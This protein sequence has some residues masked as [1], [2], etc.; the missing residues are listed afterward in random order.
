MRLRDQ[1]LAVSDAFAKAVRRSEAR[2]STIV[3][4]SGNAISRLR[5]GADM[6]SERVHNGLQWFSDNWPLLADA[7][8][9]ADVPRPPKAIAPSPRPDIYPESAQETAA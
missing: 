3:Y 6:G 1:L 8:W 9:P 5:E 4:G 7:Q 2:V